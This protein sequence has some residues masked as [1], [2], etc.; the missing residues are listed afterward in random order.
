MNDFSSPRLHVLIDGTTAPA[1][2]LAELKQVS[3]RGLV[4]YQ[5]LIAAGAPVLD[6]EMFTNDWY[7]GEAARILELLS[8][9]E[10]HG[11]GFVLREVLT[12]TDCDDTADAASRITLDELRSIVSSG[13]EERAR[14]EE[15][16]DLRY[17][18]SS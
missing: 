15:L 12:R 3:A 14:I 4:E 18:R 8:G 16:D 17:G 2:V 11:V 10:A 5:G 6:V 7:D 1:R 9:W 13:E